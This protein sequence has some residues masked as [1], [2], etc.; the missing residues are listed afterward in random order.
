MQTALILYTQDNQTPVLVDLYEN[1]NISLNY[2]FN[3]IKELTPKGN[4]SRTFRIPFTPTNASIFGFIQENTFQFSGF[5]PKRKINASITVDTIPIIE[6]YVQFKAAYTSN[7][8]VSDLEIVFFGNTVDFFKTIG[9]ADFK[10][11]IGAELQNNFDLV[12][13]YDNLATLNGSNKVYLGLADRGQNWVGQLNEAGTRSIYSTDQSIVPTIGELTPFVSARYIFNK[14]FALSGFEFNDVDSA[15]LVEQLDQ[16]W[17]PWTGEAG[18]IQT[19]GNPETAKFQLQGGVEGDT[20]TSADFSAI[21]LD[22]GLT[23]YGAPLPSMT[24]VFDYGNNVTGNEYTASISARFILQ[25]KC[26]AEID[27]NL[28]TGFQLLF[29]LIRTYGGQK[30]LYPYTSPFNFYD[31]QAGA[32]EL[33]TPKPAIAY[34]SWSPTI[35]ADNYL[36]SGATVE[37]FI[38]IGTSAI[39]SWGGTITLRDSLGSTN[40]SFQSNSITKPFFGNPIDWAANAPV[41]KCS[42]FIS[43]L[44]KMFNLVVIADDINPKL[45]TFLPIQEYLSQGNAKD[46]SNKI[47]ISKDITLTS[48]ADYQAQE[49]IWTYKPSTDYLNSLYNSQGNRAFGR[50]LLIDP[51]NDFTTNNYKVETMFSPTPLALIKATD[52]PI[53]KFI[54]NSGQYV[55]GGPRILYYTNSTIDINLYNNDANTIVSESLVL[56]S[57]YTTAIPNLADEDLNFGQEIPL[58]QITATPYKTL[59]QRYWNDYIADIYAP[60]AR[61][62][63]AFFALD[64]A[65]IYQFQFNDKIFIRD[66]YYRILEISD[67]VVGMQDTVKVKLI[68]IVSATPDCLLHP[69]ATINVDGSVPFLDAENESAPATEACCNKYGYFWVAPEC[70]AILRDGKGA[71]G[72]REAIKDDISKPTS[73]I[74]N[75]KNGL[76]QVNNSVVKEDNDRSIVISD[77]SYLGASNNGSFVSGDR[78]YVEDGLGSVTVVGT[79]AKAINNGITLG[80]GGT[81]AGEY[82]SGIIQVRGFGDWTNNTTPI[83]M[84]TDRGLYITM[85]DDCVWYM[86]LMLTVGQ[87]SAGIDGNGVIEFNIQMT[88]SAGVLSVKDAII[89]SEN[90]ETISGNFE[91]GVDI[92]G[93]TFAPQLLLKNSTY[94][95]DNIFVG[96]QI[97][98]NQYHYE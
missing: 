35:L 15:T 90:L 50:L 84:T 41:M 47:D 91:L 95:Q 4:Y 22:N 63:E 51:E 31:P 72:D 68:K 45:L 83:T 33:N 5:N 25:A 42:E 49:N 61:I 89:V 23:F 12:L 14:I 16:M 97:I 34:N 30:Q 78:N 76:I 74:N 57:H 81:Y 6:G 79:A 98:Y 26:I 54:S 27:T 80:S 94:P 62:I 55:N 56:F 64:F 10:N 2:S 46:W 66:S 21:T 40:T 44:F 70:Y 8:E 48:T 1:E 38:L 11:Y 17:I 9:D 75:A 18:Y 93:L 52:F 88:S 3:D 32:D 77:T 60:D 29:G 85:P 59:Y 92:S 20:L 53:P 87:I 28:P 96:G 19:Q 58:H 39:L 73:D 7:G 82:Q 24:E 69:G 43:S 67:Y 71:G 13:T 86:K 36:P 37:P 65:D